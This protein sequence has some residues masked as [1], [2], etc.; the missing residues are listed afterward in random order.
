MNRRSFFKFLAASA[1]VVAAPSIAAQ[2]LTKADLKRVYEDVL[3][4][5]SVDREYGM[6]VCLPGK[7]KEYGKW[8]TQ[9]LLLD[10][11]KHL[12]RGTTVEI[13][14]V[15]DCNY[16]LETRAA[17]YTNQKIAYSEPSGL[18][19]LKPDVYRGFLSAGSFRI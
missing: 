4:P 6:A 9:F 12:P 3:K 5:N 14:V 1:A 16:G 19:E 2:G 8:A 13:R 17:W 11:R 10:A 7:W 15:T 18:H